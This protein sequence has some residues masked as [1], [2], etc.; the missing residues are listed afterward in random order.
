MHHITLY[1]HYDTLTVLRLCHSCLNLLR[2][3]SATVYHS[4]A[5]QTRPYMS[6]CNRRGKPDK[7]LRPPAKEIRGKVTLICTGCFDCSGL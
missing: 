1:T 3:Y 6:K 2:Y 5:I 7:C 4:T